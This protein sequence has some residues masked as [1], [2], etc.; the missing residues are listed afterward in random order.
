TVGREWTADGA[1]AIRKP[2]RTHLALP[3][4]KGDP[5]LWK[6]RYVGRTSIGGTFHDLAWMLFMVLALVFGIFAGLTG[7]RNETGEQGFHDGLANVLSFMF[8][9][10]AAGLV[11]GLGLR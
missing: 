6:E 11:I 1:K 3:P 7:G 8:V 4:L 9:V 5:L 2:V 10:A